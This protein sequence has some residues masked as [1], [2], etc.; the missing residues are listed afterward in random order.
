[1]TLQQTFQADRK[2]E[3][4]TILSEAKRRA[5]LTHLQDADD[6]VATVQELANEIDLQKDGDSGVTPVEL[7]HSDL[8]RLEDAGVVEFD[9]RS[10]TVR[11]QG[12]TELERLLQF[13]VADL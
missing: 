5:I 3:L 9:Q 2:D 11:Y 12:S 10:R 6:G 7:V 13:V 8:P 4:L 1:M